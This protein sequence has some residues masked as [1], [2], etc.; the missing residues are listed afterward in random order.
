MSEK[1]RNKEEG[2]GQRR[3]T[4]RRRRVES[5][6]RRWCYSTS[7]IA[8]YKLLFF[9][10]PTQGRLTAPF[11]YPTCSLGFVYPLFVTSSGNAQWTLKNQFPEQ[12]SNSHPTEM[13]SIKIS[14]NHFSGISRVKR[15]RKKRRTN[16][17]VGSSAFSGIA[18][19][20]CDRK[21][22]GLLPHHSIC[23]RTGKADGE[24][25]VCSVCLCE[26]EKHKQKFKG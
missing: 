10:S 6:R 23:W 17:I 8:S 19:F 20:G 5:G 18:S 1:Q 2:D 25:R 24:P 7:A 4:G 15:E 9:A 13:L 16:N 22:K 3:S 11:V 21:K 26:T 12:F 14:Y